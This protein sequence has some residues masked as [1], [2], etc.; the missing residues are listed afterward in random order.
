VCPGCQQPVRIRAGQKKRWHFAH[1]HLQECP[2]SHESPIVLEARAVLYEWLVNK[3]KEDAVTLEKKLESDLLPHPVDCWVQTKSG[4]IAYWIIPSQIKPR[5]RDKLKS[6]FEQQDVQIN[7]VFLSE[8]LRE[9]QGNIHLTTTER[10]LSQQ[11]EYNDFIDRSG[12]LQFGLTLHY[13]DPTNEILTT[14]RTLRIVHSPQLYSGRKQKHKMVEVLVHP[15]TGEFVHPGEH[16]Y[17][18]KIGKEKERIKREQEELERKRREQME[19]FSRFFNVQY[20]A[21]IIQPRQDVS[22]G[23]IDKQECV[24]IICEKVKTEWGFITQAGKRICK[25]CYGI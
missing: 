23:V 20:P 1:K 14:F 19:Q 13:L 18:Q 5:Q 21:N 12:N 2:L 22:S 16:E 7:W 17:L 6:A 4:N 11:S 10:E 25:D 3:F 15:K 24:C 8:M 9:D